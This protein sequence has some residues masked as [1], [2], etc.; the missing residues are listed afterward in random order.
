LSAHN[1]GDQVGL[2]I[3]A[4]G[5]Q[6]QGAK[7]ESV[8]R[9]AQAISAKNIV[10]EV[11]VGFIKGRPTVDEALS[12][13]STARVIVYPLFASSGYFT[14]DRL[15][16]L[17]DRA[18]SAQRIVSILP[19]FGLDPGLPALLLK[20][21]D[22]VV[23]ASGL[24]DTTPIILLAHGSRRSSASREATEQIASSLRRLDGRRRVETAFLEERPFVN[25][26]AARVAQPV[27]VLGLFSGEGVHGA[28]D[29]KRLVAELGR[30]DVVYVGVAGSFEGV[31][32]LVASSVADAL[33]ISSAL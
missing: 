20:Q 12:S 15:V 17:L 28:A 22:Q 18:E 7:N 9:I 2:I 8:M 14:R 19:P 10:T 32:D 4:H 5:E 33:S 24:A 21:A 13:L 30:D 11:A 23:R 25:Q 3:A 16:Q 6:Q 1:S 29:A 31:D 27:V 26:V